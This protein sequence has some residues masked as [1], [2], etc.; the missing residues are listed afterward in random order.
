[1]NSVDVTLARRV[2]K[3]TWWAPVGRA[4]EWAVSLL[5]THRDS[6]AAA[7]RADQVRIAIIAFGILT[8]VLW[9]SPYA[10]LG[11][12]LAA[13]GFVIPLNESRRRSWTIK[14][15]MARERDVVVQQAGRVERQER[16]VLVI[17]GTG[18]T[19]R[20]LRLKTLEHEHS[21]E[22]V[23]FRCGGKKRA[24]VVLCDRATDPGEDEELWIVADAAQRDVIERLVATP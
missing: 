18:E 24:R 7:Q 13:S 19:I 15:R 12:L 1:M 4:L 2:R 6:R 23:V 5:P 14:L 22:L 11:L 16:K 8:V 20:E 10:P 21:D 9:N 3:P 17:D